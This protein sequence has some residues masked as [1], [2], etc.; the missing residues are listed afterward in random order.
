[1]F[2]LLSL[3]LAF[4]IVLQ[5]RIATPL[6]EQR[7][8][9]YARLFCSLIFAYSAVGLLALAFAKADLL[10]IPIFLASSLITAIAIFTSA[11]S[12]ERIYRLCQSLS[13]DVKGLIAGKSKQERV[14][15]LLIII[16]SLAIVAI[17]IG[18]V[19]HPDA[20][21][22]HAGYAAQ[23][24]SKGRFFIDGGLHQGLTG[25]ADLANIA[26]YQ[27][28]TTWL[29]RTIQVLPLIPLIL[30]LDRNGSYRLFI[31]AFVSAP[32]FLGWATS[33]K[34][35]FL[36]DICIA[37]C[38]IT[39]QLNQDTKKFFMLATAMLIG[40]SFKI[41]AL[42]IC[43]PIAFA[44]L[45]SLPQVA[46]QIYYLRKD[47]K[48]V[49]VF[50][51]AAAMLG[52]IFLFRH[53]VSGNPLYPLLS[54]Y[55]TPSN[56][57]AL[58]FEQ[59]LRGYARNRF[60][61][62]MSLFV[63]TD[64]R[65]FTD[66]LGP[67][68]LV[69]FAT[70]LILYKSQVQPLQALIPVAAAQLGLLLIFG[71]GRA[72]YYSAPAAL[73]ICGSKD[74][75]STNL[76]GL[77]QRMRLKTIFATILLAQLILF[78]LLTATS[79]SQTMSAVVSYDQ[80]MRQWA[81]GYDAS[82]QLE[83]Y[84]APHLNLAFRNTRLYYS[85]PYIDFHRFSKCLFENSTKPDNSV[86]DIDLCSTILGVQSIMTKPGKLRLSTKFSCDEKKVVFAQR[87]PFKISRVQVDIC[88]LNG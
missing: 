70:R 79:L 67:C 88:T 77:A 46:K 87:N 66:I 30:L 14:S 39:W 26:F 74:L 1:M 12:G 69:I 71:Q 6:T 19:N 28:H 36:G 7:N 27:E 55:I 75:A 53:E 49:L 29:I 41:S 18:P 85:K 35:M 38:Y 5:E 80:A 2:S 57:Q 43:I 20:A 54:K 84:P 72:D 11:N 37:A 61:F 56:S 4:Y 34:P 22:Y 64:L 8:D 40:I 51:A 59:S 33:G 21:D 83:D 60:L 86:S 44:M 47:I 50:L 24:L 76:A 68:M 45:R 63:P 73:M 48:Y 25:Y 31:L 15:G 17:S 42:I 58:E 78:Y 81:Y 62:P 10:Q 3:W 23:Y 65:F 52:G 82:K 13:H 32:V 16:T 9:Q